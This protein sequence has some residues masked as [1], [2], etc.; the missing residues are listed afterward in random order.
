VLEEDPDLAE[1]LPAALRAG[2]V[3]DCLAKT[4]SIAEGNWRSTDVRLEHD[5]IGLLV[6]NGLL[7]RRVGIDGRFGAE[8]LGAGDLLRPWHGEDEAPAL[9]ATTGWRVLEPTRVALL[10]RAFSWTLSRYP[11]IAGGLVE[12]ALV[13]ARNLAVGMAIVH[14][15]RV[16]VRLRMLFWHMASRWGHVRADGVVLRHRLTHAVLADMV[17]ARRPTVSTAMAELARA[18][19]VSAT[20]E[21]WLL[22]GEPPGELRDVEPNEAGPAETRPAS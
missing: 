21:G 14:Q 9:L 19:L 18:G 11:Q 4:V 2:A 3:A 6:L 8:L 1:A 22:R 16:E 15:P 12:R 7:I 10:D 5:A 20:D 13:R 17:A